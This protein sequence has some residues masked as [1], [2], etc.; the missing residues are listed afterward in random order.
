MQCYFI[1]GGELRDVTTQAQSLDHLVEGSFLSQ[2]I[3]KSNKGDLNLWHNDADAIV[4]RGLG[5]YA[6]VLHF[7]TRLDDRFHL[8]QRNVFAMLKLDKVLF[9]VDNFET[10][11]VV[12]LTNITSVKPALTILFLFTKQSE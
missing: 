8:A 7:R 5:M 2:A 11:V 6:A 4:F 3:S 1:V 12:H 10:A 9:A